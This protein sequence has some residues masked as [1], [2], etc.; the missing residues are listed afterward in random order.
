MRIDGYYEK[1]LGWYDIAAG[2]AIL[3]EAGGLLKPVE[4]TSPLTD[5][6]CDFIVSNG[7]IQEWLC[8]TILS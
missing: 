2:T 6:R 1:F 4:E 8:A 5:D 7:H 3:R